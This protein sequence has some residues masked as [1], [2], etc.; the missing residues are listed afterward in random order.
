MSAEPVL[1]RQALFIPLAKVWFILCSF[2]MQVLLPNLLEADQY[3]DFGVVN[4]GISV[5]NMIMVTGSIQAVSKFVSEDGNS[6][7]AIRRAALRI[8]VFFG[9]GLALA[10][11]LLAPV[12][13]NGFRDPSLTGFIRISAAIPACYAFY[14]VYIGTLNGLRRFRA[15][16]LFD[17]AYATIRCGGILGAA[18]LGFGVGGVFAAFASAAAIILVLAFLHGRTVDGSDT[19]TFPA[20]R[21]ILFAAPV[22]VFVGVNQ[23]LLS[24]DL[25]L[26]KR[27]LDPAVSAE[28]SGAY[29]GML[30]L[31]MLPYML[32]VSVNFIVFPLISRSTFVDDAESTRAYI[33]QSLRITLLLTLLAE[34]VP[35][36]SPEQALGFLYWTKPE[37]GAYP[38]A[39]ML[40]AVGYTAFTLF[41][42]T[43]T[44]INGSGKPSVSLVAGAAVLIG[45]VAMAAALIPSMGL[46]GAAMATAIAFTIGITG[47]GL[48]LFRRHG[49]FLAPLTVVRGLTAAAASYGVGQVMSLDGFMFLAEAI[50]C[51]I[52]FIAVL[53]VTGELGKADIVRAL[54]IVR[55][56]G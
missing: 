40:L 38:S 27:M 55:R 24:A 22:V 39:M 9:G 8:Q 2:A 3:G 5:I 23:L 44:I 20:K 45:Q 30:N 17:M 50:V 37:F 10:Y 33:T 35:F 15:Q 16:G 34:S 21:L 36:G 53:I 52:A 54:K 25:F 18:W 11:F 51:A 1:S 28:L 46:E 49:A 13:A 31:A 7:R 32:V 47:L 41:S 14:A 19:E 43:T 42:V 12:I 4:R 29:V 26:A 6:A 48:F 56:R